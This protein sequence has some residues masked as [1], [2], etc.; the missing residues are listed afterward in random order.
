VANPLK[1]EKIRKGD[2][3]RQSDVNR[4]PDDFG[5]WIADFGLETRLGLSLSI[6]NGPPAIALADTFSLV[7]EFFARATDSNPSDSAIYFAISRIEVPG[8][9]AWETVKKRRFRPA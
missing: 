7:P 4:E 6:P 3:P 1:S 8:G 5:F 9:F 2:L